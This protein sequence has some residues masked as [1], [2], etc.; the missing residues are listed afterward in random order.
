MSLIAKETSK[1]PD[2][3]LLEGGVYMATC[4]GVIDLGEQKNERYNKYQ[5]KC[6]LIF[7]IIDEF[8]DIE[9]EQKPRWLSRTYTTSLHANSALRADIKRWLGRDLT[10][11]ELAAFDLGGML[12]SSCQ[13]Q[14]L[15]DEY[16]GKKYNHIDGVIALPRGTK[17]P[18][19]TSEMLLYDM[20]KDDQAT[21][22]KLPEWIQERI[23]RSPDYARAHEGT[24]K[25]DV[26]VP[27]DSKSAPEVDTDTGEINIP[28]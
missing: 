8:V 10:E 3:P 22:D 18:K 7:E 20:D 15:I 16:E 25:M 28:F 21:M 4:I 11:K 24:Q 5:K 27:E 17:V 14:V 1:K 9:G 12:G 26:D 6:L 23:K 13:V 2:V 19:P